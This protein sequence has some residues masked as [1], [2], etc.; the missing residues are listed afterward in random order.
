MWS[1]LS[2]ALCLSVLVEKLKCSLFIPADESPLSLEYEH[3]VS[4]VLLHQDCTARSHYFHWGDSERLLDFP[5]FPSHASCQET[6]FTE[7]LS[8]AVHLRYY[9]T[10]AFLYDNWRHCIIIYCDKTAF[11]DNWNGTYVHRSFD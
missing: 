5:S 2:F 6:E 3:Y 7:S 10:I 1:R 8:R 9:S 4:S 11:L